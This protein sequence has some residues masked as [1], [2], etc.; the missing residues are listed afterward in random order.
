[1]IY[2]TIKSV[3]RLIL[4]NF[5]K[6]SLFLFSISSISISL[7]LLELE[8]EYALENH[9]QIVNYLCSSS[10]LYN[11]LNFLHRRITRYLLLMIISQNLQ[12]SLTPSMCQYKVDDKYVM[13]S[14]FCSRTRQ[15]HLFN[16]ETHKKY[17]VAYVLY[18]SDSVLIKF[19]S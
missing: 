9:W 15:E 18:S 1:M 19:V 3:R 16:V 2:T 4:N 5:N 12:I 13:C 11:A 10:C 6:S 7:F 14:G 17:G 8:R